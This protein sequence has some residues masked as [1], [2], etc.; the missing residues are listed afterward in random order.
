MEEEADAAAAFAG[1]PLDRPPEA[2][3]PTWSESLQVAWRVLRDDRFYGAMGGLGRIY[4]SSISRYAADHGIE[5]EALHD[6][7]LFLSAIDDEYVRFA[8]EQ[9]EAER[10]KREAEMKQQRGP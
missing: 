10:K 2:E 8:N 7:V 6:F 4:Y 9:A 1:R 3:W 5:G